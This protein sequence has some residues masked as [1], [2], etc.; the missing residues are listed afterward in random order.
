MT[1]PYTVRDYSRETATGQISPKLS[2]PPGAET[3]SRILKSMGCKNGTDM[4]YLLAKFGGDLLLHGSG[5]RTSSEFCVCACVCAFV[6]HAYHGPD[7]NTGMKRA[8]S[9][10]T[11]VVIYWWILMRFLSFSEE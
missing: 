11:I 3:T 7:I 1:M 10:G 6:C 5:R 2:E 9:N 4:L 8:H